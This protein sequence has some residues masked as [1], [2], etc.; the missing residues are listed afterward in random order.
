M[1]KNEDEKLN[2][3]LTYRDAVDILRVVKDSENCDSLEF[4]FGDMKFSL[5]RSGAGGQV[6]APVPRPMPA[7]PVTPA[8]AAVPAPAAAV[9]PAPA[10]AAPPKPAAAGTDA[11]HVT[12]TAPMLG[13]FFAAATPTAPPFVKP[14]D[15]VAGGDTVGLIEVM[16]LFTPITA[17]VYGK[18]VKV[19]AVNGTLV[20]FGQPLVVIDP[21]G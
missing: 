4:E 18:V 17:G 13:I 1:P 14:G 11:G 15:T 20:E 7:A 21:A 10:P 5:T 2:Y 3:T 9:A 12:I 8:A 6:A 16:K 19:I